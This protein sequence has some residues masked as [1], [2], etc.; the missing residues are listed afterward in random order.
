M[1][2]LYE[3]CFILRVSKECNL[4][5]LLAIGSGI[6]EA[7]DGLNLW[8]GGTTLACPEWC[9]GLSLE[10]T[11]CSV[12]LFKPPAQTVKEELLLTTIEDVHC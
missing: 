11:V 6:C 4:P 12:C 5:S 1:E 2:E 8:D 3:V 7:V 10:D 9:G